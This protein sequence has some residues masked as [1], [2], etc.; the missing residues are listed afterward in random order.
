V[1]DAAILVNPSE[2]LEI[3]LI[4]R[5]VENLK[6]T[7]QA[8][9]VSIKKALIGYMIFPT[10]FWGRWLSPGL[11]C[12]HRSAVIKANAVSALAGLPK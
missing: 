10:G 7:Q 11:S 5:D 1:V 2:A 12:R 6:A 8:N 9:N 4:Q 3:P